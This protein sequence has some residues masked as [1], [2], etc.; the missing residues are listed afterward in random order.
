[1]RNAAG[2]YL[3]VIEKPVMMC[4]P[5][6]AYVEDPISSRIHW[7][8]SELNELQTLHYTFHPTYVAKRTFPFSS[9]SL[10]P[11]SLIKNARIK[12]ES[13]ERHFQVGSV[14]F[15]PSGYF[16]GWRKSSYVGGSML[17]KGNLYGIIG[18]KEPAQPC[19]GLH[20]ESL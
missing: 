19:L 16:E 1:M 6:P 12:L 8:E 11:E 17:E 10:P 9:G 2:N 13:K 4:H 20:N 14:R 15:C 3:K 5:L 18:D 7:L